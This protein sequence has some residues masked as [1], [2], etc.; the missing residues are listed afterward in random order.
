M[1][2]EPLEDLQKFHD[3]LSNL[4][5]DS[6]IRINGMGT[7]DEVFERIKQKLIELI[8]DLDHR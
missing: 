5:K 4:A 3:A 6:C 1:D 8:G 7:Q 2:Y